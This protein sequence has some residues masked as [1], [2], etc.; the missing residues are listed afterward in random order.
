[1]FSDTQLLEQI[2]PYQPWLIISGVFILFLLL[3]ISRKHLRQRVDEI[4]YRLMRERGLLIWFWLNAP[5][6]IIHELSHAL[7]VL[8]FRPFG[9]RITSITLFRIKPVVQRNP[10]GRVM[11]SGGRQSLQLGEVQ[12]VRPQGR[13]MSY[14][15]DGVSGI[16][17][18]FGGIAMLTVLYWVA[19]GYNLW[20]FPIDAS[21]HS[22]QV[23]RPG[24]PWWTLTFTPYLILTVTSELWPS[25][26]DWRGARWLV[27][28]LALLL[29]LAVLLIWYIDLLEPVLTLT[30][31]IAS[32]I[33]FALLVLLG[34]DLCFLILA[35][36]IVRGVRR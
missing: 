35:E 21:S 3:R 34:L 1:M 16:A 17:P 23:L 14:I 13:I 24:W 33:D 10:N 22:L 26:Q 8:L 27:M 20:D 2:T 18:L 7:I 29:I 25:R 9:F 15:G 36:I 32:R 6:V 5:G 11:R 30:S 28:G 12:Y 31:L 4:G 19:T